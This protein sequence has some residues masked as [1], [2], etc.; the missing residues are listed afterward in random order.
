MFGLYP[1][2][3]WPNLGYGQSQ[4]FLRASPKAYHYVPVSVREITGPDRERVYAEQARRYSS[5]GEYEGK[6]EG[7]RIIPVLDLRRV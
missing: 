6:T 3:A 4:L 2:G 7:I 5:F 1:L